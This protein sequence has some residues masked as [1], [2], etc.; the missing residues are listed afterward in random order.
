MFGAGIDDGVGVTL[1]ASRA[2]RW[3]PADGETV[4]VAGIQGDG[5]CRRER[6]T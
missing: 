6:N 4:S 1:E 3:A 5:V 2:V